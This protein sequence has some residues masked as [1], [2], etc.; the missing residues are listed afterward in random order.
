MLFTILESPSAQSRNKYGDIG[1]PCLMPLVGLKDSE[2]TPLTLTEKDTEEMHFI[3]REH[4]DS[5]K[6]KA[7]IMAIR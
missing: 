1:S 4:Q 6:P 7:D 3:T 5:G 2:K